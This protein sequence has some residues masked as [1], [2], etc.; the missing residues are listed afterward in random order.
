MVSRSTASSKCRSGVRGSHRPGLRPASPSQAGWLQ[1]TGRS[2]LQLPHGLLHRRQGV[3]GPDPPRLSLRVA[4][5]GRLGSRSRRL[6][7]TCSVHEGPS[8]ENPGTG[9]SAACASLAAAGPRAPRHR[10]WWHEGNARAHLSREPGQADDSS[11]RTDAPA[12]PRALSRFAITVTECSV[13][14]L[15]PPLRYRL[16]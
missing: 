11:E 8:C 9:A 12:P 10:G 14:V 13:G 3:R 15:F 4:S 1:T 6:S 2:V 7:I 5:V 16:P